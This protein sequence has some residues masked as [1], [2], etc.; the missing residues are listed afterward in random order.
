MCDR[1]GNAACENCGS[2]TDED[3]Q[4]WGGEDLASAKDK[5]DA[6]IDAVENKHELWCADALIVVQWLAENQQEFTSDDFWRAAAVAGLEPPEE[7]RAFGPVMM[8]AKR[9]PIVEATDQFVLCQRP[10]RNA[11]PIRVW[12]SL[13]FGETLTI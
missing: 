11:S 10:S 13:I 1:T 4:L 12:R 8:R 6:A 2:S 7:P 5:R 9:I 3:P